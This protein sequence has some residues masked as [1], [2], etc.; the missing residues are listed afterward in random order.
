MGQFYTLTIIA[1]VSLFLLLQSIAP[2]LANVYDDPRLE[3]VIRVS[4]ITFLISLIGF[5]SGTMMNKEMRFKRLSIVDAIAESVGALSTVFMAWYGLGYWSIAYG[6]L[7][8]E[9]VRQSGY[10]IRAG[11]WVRPR[12]MT[13]RIKGILDFSWKA[14]LQ[15]TVGYSIFNLDIAVAGLYL[16]TTELGFYQFAAVLAMMPAVKVLPLLRQVALPVY[17]KIQDKASHIEY[18]FLKSQRLSALLFVPVFWGVAASANSMVPAFFG[19]KWGP[20]AV[21][22]ALYCLSMPM[23]SLEQLF[24]P[25]LKSLNKMNLIIGNTVIF[26]LILIPGFFIGAR[27]GGEGMAMS[28]IFSFFIRLF[29]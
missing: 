9:T 6:V 15:A 12:M 29:V 23:R 8:L 27:Y 19:D 26:A 22:I 4:S 10:L 25:V 24:G 2:V 7:L 28:W 13:A 1:H 11:K 14:A 21:I 16:S 17:S 20:A 3:N 5:M 18:Y